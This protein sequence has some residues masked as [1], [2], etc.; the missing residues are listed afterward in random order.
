MTYAECSSQRP[1]VHVGAVRTQR[2]RVCDSRENLE[3]GDTLFNI[4][5]IFIFTG[6]PPKMCMHYNSRELSFENEMCF[7]EHSLYSY[8]KCVCAF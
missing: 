3:L 4:Y 5:T 6:C 8:S 1:M 2:T 7:N